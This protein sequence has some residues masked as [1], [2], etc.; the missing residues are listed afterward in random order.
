MQVAT[1]STKGQITLPVVARR[2]L[3][4]KPQDRVTIV[5]ENN[6]IV[7]KAAPDFMKLAGFL[8]KSK[9]LVRERKAAMQAAA[10]RGRKAR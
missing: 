7:I 10:R 1:V 5:M 9:G 2:A 3:G 6:G 8:G 4:I